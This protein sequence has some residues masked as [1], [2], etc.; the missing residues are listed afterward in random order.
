MSLGKPTRAVQAW[1]EGNKEKVKVY[2]GVPFGELSH[3]F[4]ELNASEYM[5]TEYNHNKI[6]FSGY[7]VVNY[8]LNHWNVQQAEPRKLTGGC[9]KINWKVLVKP[10]NKLNFTVTLAKFTERAHSLK[11]GRAPRRRKQKTSFSI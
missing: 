10:V 4:S 1:F 2:S 6:Y 11:R 7:M 8:N 9:K 5:F 3:L